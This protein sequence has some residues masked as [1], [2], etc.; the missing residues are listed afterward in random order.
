MVLIMCAELVFPQIRDRAEITIRRP[1]EVKIQTSWKELTDRCEIMLPRN[2]RDFNKQ[3]VKQVFRT[4]D[5]VI[6]KLGYNGQLI[7]E[8]SGYVIQVSADIPIVIKCEDEMWKLKQLPVNFSAKS[9]T[10]DGLLKSVCPGYSIDA[11]EGVQLGTIRLTKT[12]VA[13][14]LEKLKEKFGLYAY[15]KEKQLV[16]G[17]YY[18]DDTTVKPVKFNLEKNVVDNNLQY[19]SRE[20]IMLE[21]KGTSKL[22]KGKKLE[23][24]MGTPGGDRLELSYYNIK[25]MADLIKL[26]KADYDKRMADGFDGSFTA[27]GIPSVRHGWKVDLTSTL[28][29]DRVGMYYIEGVEKTFGSNGYRQAIKLGDKVV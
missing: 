10:L 11:M 3:S 12:T 2:V 18:A 27:F 15:M 1:S 20:E 14:V 6:V 9:T 5:P 22:V 7:K 8:F 23:Y 4:G 19:R 13:K 25:V 28:Y 16:V 21:I 24:V 26:V 17:K 29:P